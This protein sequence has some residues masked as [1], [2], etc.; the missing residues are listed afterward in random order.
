MRF[1]LNSNT[2]ILQHNGDDD[3][4]MA[5]HKVE[6]LADVLFSPLNV[7]A[8]DGDIRT[9]IQNLLENCHWL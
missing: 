8:G 1:N 4:R 3:K 6:N 2:Y 7:L 9:P 5:N